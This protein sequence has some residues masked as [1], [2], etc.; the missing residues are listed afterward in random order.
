MNVLLRT[1]TR[2]SL[3]K[4]GKNKDLTIQRMIDLNKKIDLVSAYYKLSKV[5][6]TKDI[7]DELKITNNWVIE[8]PSVNKHMYYDF[9]KSINHSYKYTFK[10]GANIM[11]KE[12]KTSF[13]KSYL[14]SLNQG[15]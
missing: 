8:K 9:L 11:K 14:Q 15:K 3:F 1:M 12:T 5:N 2:K 6:F 4:I 7:L 10:K 13:S